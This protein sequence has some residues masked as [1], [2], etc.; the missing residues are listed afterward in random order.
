MKKVRD[1]LPGDSFGEL[2]LVEA[3]AKRSATIKCMKND[4]EFATLN[5]E[6][7]LKSMQIIGKKRK[8]IKVDF[9][10]KLSCFQNMSR[11]IV[12]KYFDKMEK[13]KFK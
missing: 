6:N 10:S 8:E 1:L 13:V 2:A 9:L 3:G 12:T 5:K 7:F 4:C 11:R